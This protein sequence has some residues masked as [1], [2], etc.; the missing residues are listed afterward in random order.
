MLRQGRPSQYIGA[1]AAGLAASIIGGLI[2]S[3]TFRGFLVSFILGFLIGEAVRRGAR[4]N[5]GP[6]FMA[7]AGISAF[8]GLIIVRLE[9]N[10]MSLLFSII[11]AGVAAYRLSE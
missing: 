11:T 6:I 3:L 7:I 10:P 9:L 1:A 8:T 4:G 2:L 5:R